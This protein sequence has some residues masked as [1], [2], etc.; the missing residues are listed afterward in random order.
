MGYTVLSYAAIDNEYEL[1]KM[2]LKSGAKP[3]YGLNFPLYQIC[4]A[5]EKPKN[6]NEMIKLLIAYGANLN[7]KQKN[8]N[9]T[10]LMA[11]IKKQGDKYAKLLI[12][13]GAKVNVVN[14][15]GETPL[16]LAVDYYANLIDVSLVQYLISQGSDVNVITKTGHTALS[17][18]AYNGYPLILD[19]FWKTVPT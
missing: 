10:P 19:S 8:T 4:W 18:A 12:Q 2:L 16:I 1:A 7:K 9:D 14:S 3:D 17:I 11:T 5:S 15:E 6:Q 13:Y